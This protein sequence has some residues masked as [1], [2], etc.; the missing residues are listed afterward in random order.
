M[1]EDIEICHCMSVNKSVIVKA[2]KEKGLKTVEEVQDETTAGTGCGGCIPD[3]EVI[4]K[5]VNG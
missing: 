2:I 1:E 3:I 4:L 5:E